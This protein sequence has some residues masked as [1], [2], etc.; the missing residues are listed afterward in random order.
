MVWKTCSNIGN[1][2]PFLNTRGNLLDSVAALQA[3]NVSYSAIRSVG[4]KTL[5][6]FV[7]F[8]LGYVAARHRLVFA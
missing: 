5:E 2:V 7:G 1:I 6:L 4:S 3:R 8:R